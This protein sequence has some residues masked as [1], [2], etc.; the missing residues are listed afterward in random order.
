MFRLLSKLILVLAGWKV[1]GKEYKD[2]KRCIVVMAPH[3][4]NWDFVLGRLGYASLGMEVHFLMKKESFKFPLGYLIKVIGGIPVDRKHSTNVI[5]IITDM[6]RTKE[7]LILTITPEATRSLNHNW[8]RGFYYIALQSDIP[9]LLGYLD[10]SKKEAGLGCVV[11]PTG[12]YE[13]DMVK[14]EAFYKTKTALYPEKFNL[15]PVNRQKN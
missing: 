11:I 13:Q 6:F 9:L 5:S 4:S 12:N 1:I 15:S 10:F 14:I 8:K 7:H 3:T 2:I